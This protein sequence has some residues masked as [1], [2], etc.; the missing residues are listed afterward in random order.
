EDIND[1]STAQLWEYSPAT[2]IWTRK[3]DFIG[4]GLSLSAIAFSIGDKGYAGIGNDTRVFKQYD[5]VTNQWNSKKVF[6]GEERRGA[7][8]F[9][10]GN[11]GYVGAGNGQQRDFW[12]YCPG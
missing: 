12:E 9:S 10:I 4:K 1:E 8:G 11:R 7:V 3:A 5:P 2:N 6:T